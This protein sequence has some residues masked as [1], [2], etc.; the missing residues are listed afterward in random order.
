MHGYGDV[1]KL[2]DGLA[3]PSDWGARDEVLLARI[4]DGAEHYRMEGPAAPQ[5]EWKDPRP[6]GD[7]Q[8]LYREF[9][10]RHIVAR[11]PMDEFLRIHI[12]RFGPEDVVAPSVGAGGVVIPPHQP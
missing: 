9:D 12:P 1:S 3:L 6:G 4:P 2:Q 10:A 5:L 11:L 7:H 8:I